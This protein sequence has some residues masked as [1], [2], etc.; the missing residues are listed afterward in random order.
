MLINN[1]GP[2]TTK[3][4]SMQVNGPLNICKVS[5]VNVGKNQSPSWIYLPY[6]QNLS[7]R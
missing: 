2:Q 1:I 7:F 3:H 5:L 6:L 4:L